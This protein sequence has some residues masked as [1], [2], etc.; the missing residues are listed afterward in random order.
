MRRTWTAGLVVPALLAAGCLDAG[1]DRSLRR[2]FSLEPEP[3]PGRE[4]SLAA[5]AR[6]DQVGRQILAANPFAGGDISFQTV[7]ADEL[8][9]FHRDAHGLF[10]TDALVNRCKTDGELAAVL[11]SELG[12][13]VAERRNAGRMGFP[14]P[15]NDVPTGPNS[16]EAGGIPA[17]QVRL[18][19]LGM[20]ERKFPK[21]TVDRARDEFADPRT[22]TLDLL[23]TAGYDEKEYDQAAPLLKQVNRD[24]DVVRQLGGPG[25]APHWSR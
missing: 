12:R 18:A 16:M 5:A 8:A 11:C 22:V 21:K 20:M 19:E 4:P 6:V 9:V 2:V 23:K 17:D 7:G 13:M 15:I 24:S 25:A 10:I 14:E 1:I 3:P